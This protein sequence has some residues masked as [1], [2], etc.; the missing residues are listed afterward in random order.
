MRA[1]RLNDPRFGHRMRAEG[2]YAAMIGARF[3]AACRRLGLNT[4]PPVELDISQF[5]RDPS[6]PSQGSLFL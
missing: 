2:E 1:G 4:D 6:A 5:L 3:D